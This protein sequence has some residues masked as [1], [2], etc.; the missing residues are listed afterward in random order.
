MRRKERTHALTRATSAVFWSHPLHP[1]LA[2]ASLALRRVNSTAWGRRLTHRLK[3]GAVTGRAFCFRY[4]GLDPFHRSR[5][6]RTANADFAGSV[7]SD[8]QSCELTLSGLVNAAHGLRDPLALRARSYII[9]THI[10]LRMRYDDN[11]LATAARE[12]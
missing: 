10:A 9:L 6:S 3:S 1:S 12:H 5:H 4:V 11:S 8:K 2:V 7:A